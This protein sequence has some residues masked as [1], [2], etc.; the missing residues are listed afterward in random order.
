MRTRS[1]WL[2]EIPSFKAKGK[3]PHLPPIQTDPNHVVF[4]HTTHD[5]KKVRVYHPNWM[6]PPRAPGGYNGSFIGHI[7]GEIPYLDTTT[8]S[9]EP[10]T[11]QYTDSVGPDTVQYYTNDVNAA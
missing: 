8:D 5:G 2:R 7:K 4:G 1:S 10:D 3:M 9:V 6:V 11:A